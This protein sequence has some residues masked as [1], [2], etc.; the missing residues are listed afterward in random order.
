MKEDD[1]LIWEILLPTNED[2]EPL[3]T[4]DLLTNEYLTNEYKSD[5]T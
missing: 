3:T 1:F 5:V 4:N 2:C